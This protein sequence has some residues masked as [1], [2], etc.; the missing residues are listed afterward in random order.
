MK[1]KSII[2]DPSATRA[3]Y[4]YRYFLP[5][6][7]E[8]GTKEFCRQRLDELL[9]FCKDAKVDAVQFFVNILP[10]TYYM[11]AHN[12]QEQ[13]HWAG[14][15]KSVVAPALRETGVSYQLNF[16]MLLGALSYDL[17]MR[18]DYDWD[19]LV[20]QYGEETLGCACP[21]SKK[22]R[23]AMGEMLE[24]WA[25]TKPDV[26]W[27]DDDFRMH[28]HGLSGGEL[29]FYCYCDTHLNKFA[30]FIGKRYSRDELVAEILTPGAPAPLR[31]QWQKFLGN[32]MTE[33]AAWINKC[34]QGVSPETRIA[35]MTS[36]P[37]VHSAEGRNWK[38]LLMSLSGKYTPMTRPMCEIYTG[39]GVP[40][41]DNACTYKYM[42]QS[43]TTLRRIFGNDGIE[44]GP[45][46]ENTRFTTW[47]K[48]VANSRYVMI[49]GQLLGAPQITLSLNDL[50]GSPISQEPTTVPLLRDTKPQLMA[51]AALN[52]REWE[53]RG[54]VFLDDELS[55]A[56]V[57]LEE[58]AKMQD[59]GRIRKWEDTLLQCGVPAYHASCAEA[60]NNGDIVVLE[61]YTAWTPSDEELKKILSGAV[62]LDA[63]AAFVV[64]ERGFGEHLGIWAGERQRFA[65]VAEKYKIGTI[66]KTEL[67][68]PYRGY[69]WRKIKP[70]GAEISSEYIDSQNNYYPASMI[71]TNKLGGRIA[72][73][74]NVGD[75][76]PAGN[77]G[78]H[79][80]LDWLHSILSWLSKNKFSILSKIPHHALTL[81]KE[82]KGE[83][84]LALANL[85]TDPVQELTFD[86]CHN[87][88]I[89]E[90]MF[91]SKT[92]EWINIDYV[93]TENDCL[94]RYGITFK[95]NLNVFEW[96]IVKTVY[97]IGKMK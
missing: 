6:A 50:D 43:M 73:Y 17:D 37:D 38:E 46:L 21:L 44:F 72:V 90:L 58:N 7:P 55:A 68:I 27:I 8:W 32:T 48:S 1:K 42:S 33:T 62:L 12:A 51:L 87:G 83:T 4:N 84:L 76:S 40:V 2:C 57:H 93:M 97:L 25:S 69:K 9:V 95:C 80:R 28:N 30:E 70:Q 89:S 34:I 45:E 39:T 13:L 52:L 81:I 60:A 3:Y 22:F 78:N 88:R 5:Y 35:L 15:M 24:L 23:R 31:L 49:L 47:C 26:I 59:L 41:K 29:D 91:L 20:N 16:Q 85:G 96:F 53:N 79:A 36:M 66:N 18:A 11:P 65:C 19:C 63:D 92:G 56:K 86:I 10:G 64:Q 74:N 14:W 61:G 82:R 77:F 67:R 54:V 71:F 94:N 75:L